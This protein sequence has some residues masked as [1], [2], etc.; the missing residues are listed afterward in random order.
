MRTRGAIV[1][2]GAGSSV[3]LAVAVTVIELLN[4]EFSA[5]V[6]LPVGLLAGAATAVILATRYEAIDPPVRHTVDATA[7]FGLAIV[8]VLAVR[9]VNLAGLRSVLS[10]DVAVGIAVLAAVLTGLA[11]WR[12]TQ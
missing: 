7:G 6:G 9:Y 12:T 5:L 11:S 3:F 2:V 4:V 8:A 10:A 1:A